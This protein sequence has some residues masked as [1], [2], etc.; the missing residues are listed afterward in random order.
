[1]CLWLWLASALSLLA[2][3]LVNLA[4]AASGGMAISIQ[5]IV[6]STLGGDTTATEGGR[7]GVSRGHGTIPRPGLLLDGC[8]ISGSRRLRLG[9]LASVHV[10][11]AGLSRHTTRQRLRVW[12]RAELSL[13]VGLLADMLMSLMSQGRS[14]RS[15]NRHSRCWSRVPGKLGDL[16]VGKLGLPSL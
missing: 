5:Q 12:S 8:L 15:R 9:L 6:S 3:V 1:M 2:K 11:T 16:Q 4:N 10:L 7:S 13:G 14:C